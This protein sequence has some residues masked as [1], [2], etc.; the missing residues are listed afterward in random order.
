MTLIFSLLFFSTTYVFISPYLC[1][2]L[3]KNCYFIN[4]IEKLNRK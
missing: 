1:Y 2:L 4:I 3:L